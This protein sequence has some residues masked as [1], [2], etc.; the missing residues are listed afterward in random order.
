M[1]RAR[2]LSWLHGV[3]ARGPIP[4]L[5]AYS[6]AFVLLM[7]TYPWAAEIRPKV[8][9]IAEGLANPWGLAFLPDG[10]MLV[11]ERSGR[12][13]LV[14][15][16]TKSLSGP[17]PGLPSI[18]AQGQGGLLGLA[19][20]PDF[21]TN[22]RV[23]MCFSEARGG[24]AGSSIFRARLA[25]NPPS[26]EE[27]VVIFRQMPA[28]NADRHFGCRLAFAKDGMLFAT[29]GDRGTLS[30]EAQ[31]LANHIGKIVR[32]TPDG[33]A[34]PDNPF[35][36]QAGA[37][38][39]IWSYGHRNIQGATIDARSGALF[40]AEHG[41]RGGDE[42]NRPEAGKNY[43]WP[44]I[45]FGVDYSGAKIGIGTAKA[46]MEQ[47]LYY[48]DPSIA[49]SG[50]MIYQGNKFPDWRG[51][52]FIGALAG[53][54]VVRLGLDRGRVTSETRMLEN[55]GRRI[56]DIVEGPDG[57]IY[58]LTDEANGAVLRLSPP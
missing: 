30:N 39:E 18:Y 28:G 3:A 20:D 49:P 6:L 34:P 38:P 19:L 23:F 2:Y 32:L 9:T 41:A 47:P 37:R 1:M 53:E 45:T 4:R 46:G 50:A 22:R 5:A 7:P 54:M 15:P 58:L 42:I 31:N 14:N 51:Q 24:G 56:R 21:A 55:L 33:A 17:I 11:T 35:I 25:A 8:E 40:T 36:G 27:G 57:L 48:W 12:L 29:F 10:R 43:G 44:I 13:R 16:R 26:L 52:I